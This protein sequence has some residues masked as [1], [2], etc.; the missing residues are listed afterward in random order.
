MKTQCPGKSYLVLECKDTFGGTWVTHRYPGVR[1]DSDLY[2]FGYR[3]KP[4]MGKPIATAAEILSYMGEVIAENDLARHI[5]Y[6]HKIT[7]ASWSTADNR[8][9]IDATRL[10]TGQTLRFTA[11]FLWMCQGYYDHDKA[12][13]PEWP[14]MKDFKGPLIHP[15]SWPDG[16]DVTGKRVVVIGSGA[17]AAT[18]IPAL[19]QQGAA[20]VTMLQR[21]P[22]YFVCGRNSN[23]LANELRRLEIDPDWIHAIVRKKILVDGNIFDRRSREEPEKVRKELLAGIRAQLGDDFPID[24]H[25]SPRYRPWQQRV[26][27][28]PD[29]DMF[30][31]IRRGKADAVTDEIDHFDAGGIVL[32]SGGRLDADIIVAA[33][34]FRLSVLGGIPFSVD[35]KPVDWANT[36]TYRG[37]MFTGVPNMVWVFGYFRASWT[38]RVDMMGDFVSRLLHHMDASGV[39][40]VVPRLRAREKDIPLGDWI[41]ADNF[42]PGYLRRDMH[43]MPKSGNTREWQNTQD[44]WGEK[45]EFPAIDLRD[46]VFDYDFA[47]P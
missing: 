46:D 41:D 32:K 25:F 35:G 15:Q 27:F 1:S 5:R 29:G 39:R 20:K 10:D 23:D 3:F 26:A 8:W 40:R 2:T 7:A 9:T 22:T 36:V 14:G 44:Y 21:S 43:L 47:K 13:L 17:T 30:Q 33:T 34:G 12:Y 16:L 4:W 42:N 38:L 6:R 28:I 24:P 19:A 37:M 11:G 45:D 18:V 31:E